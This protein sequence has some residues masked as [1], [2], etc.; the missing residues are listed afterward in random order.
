[1]KGVKG[2]AKAKTYEFTK[3]ELAKIKAKDAKMTPAQRRALS[4]A[5]VEANS[6]ANNIG[7]KKKKA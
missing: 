2:M 4:K 1:M 7:R 3:E 5:L 6:A